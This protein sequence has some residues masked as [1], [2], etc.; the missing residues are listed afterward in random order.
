MQTF[1]A[2]SIDFAQYLCY[3]YYIKHK[4]VILTE[5]YICRKDII[6]KY[7]TT[8]NAIWR[9]VKKGKITPLCGGKIFKKSEA[10]KVFGEKPPKG[11]PRKER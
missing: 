7:N 4:G 3:N 6:N 10:E 5:E 8:Y 1:F 11:R 2:F 9:Y